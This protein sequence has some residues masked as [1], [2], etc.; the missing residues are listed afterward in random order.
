MCNHIYAF[1]TDP[2][3]GKKEIIQ[4][5]AFPEVFLTLGAPGD[6]LVI[7]L[8]PRPGRP[9]S[10]NLNLVPKED[11]RSRPCSSNNAS[12]RK[13]RSRPSSPNP[14]TS[15]KAPPDALLSLEQER[16]VANRRNRDE[17]CF[18]LIEKAHT[19]QLQKRVV[20]GGHKR[21]GDTGN[22]KEKAQH[23]KGKSGGKKK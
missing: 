12:P 11:A 22:R 13:T 9:L 3:K 5:C 15:N 18:S 19:P 10:L 6:N 1:L 4:P 21:K 17:D 8:S 7:P 20:Q 16:V 14:G 23:G 2:L